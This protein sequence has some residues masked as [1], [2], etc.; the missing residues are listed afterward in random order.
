MFARFC[1]AIYGARKCSAK[2]PLGGKMKQFLSVLLVLSAALVITPALKADTFNFTFTDL[3]GISGSG[4]LSGTYEGQGNPWLIT[5]C[6]SCI[7]NDGDDSGSVTLVTNPNG[8]DFSSTVN[9]ITYDDLLDVFQYSGAYLDSEGLDFQFGNGDDLNIFFG[10]SVGGGG[11]DFYGWYDSPQG[12]GDFGFES[13]TGSFAITSS[14]IPSSE[15]P[16][17]EPGSVLLLGTGLLGLAFVLIRKGRRP[18]LTLNS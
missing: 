3:G 4:T 11:A 9:G 10:Y 5:G 7:F 2:F 6:T 1:G 8:P 13:E 14:D 18:E 17:P 16:T 12:N 15:Y